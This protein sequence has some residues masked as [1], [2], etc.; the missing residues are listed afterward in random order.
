M[1]PKQD[2]RRTVE[3]LRRHGLS[4][5]EILQR[6]PVS[7]SSISLWCRGVELSEVQQQVLLQRKLTAGEQG[8]A[9]IAELRQAGKL[10]R[11]RLTQRRIKPMIE[12]NGYEVERVRSLY[13]DERLG[14]REIAERLG[15]SFWRVYELMRQHNIPRR[16]G[17]EQNYA[18]YKTKPQFVLRENLT[19]AD[20]QLRIAG[21]MLYWAEG[22]KNWTC[23]DFANSDPDLVALFV[24]FL[25][26]ICGAAK[27]RLHVHLY[28]YAD[29]DIET[30]KTF[31][32]ELT[33]I[34][35]SQFIRPYVRQLTPN[36]TGR[37]MKWGLVHITYSDGRLLQVIL[38]WA[39]DFAKTWGRYQS[40]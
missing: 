31:W 18:T 14:V 10:T 36:V 20:E 40:G 7:K 16:R 12:T 22:A 32:S 5:R 1:R 2:A 17:S 30:L 15:I 29:Q 25:R 24:T 33:G 34:P 8:L 9:L 28:A 39:R 4:Y 37:K 26:R 13:A 19:A 6:V 21:A 11:R 23:V 27:E 3:E 38:R 35:L